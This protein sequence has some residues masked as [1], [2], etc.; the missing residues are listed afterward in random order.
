MDDDIPAPRRDGQKAGPKRSEPADQGRVARARQ[1]FGRAARPGSHE[2][3]TLSLIGKSVLAASVS[4]YIAYNLMQAQSPAFAPFSAVLI[5]Q[6]TAYQSLLQSLRYVGAV[7]VGVGLQGAVGSVTGSGM[8]TFVLVAVAALTIGRWRQL[9]SQGTQV[10]TAA[11]FA[12]STY[13]SAT[14][15]MQGLTQ[16][17]QIVLLVVIGCGVGV[18]VNVF[19]MPPM[20][21]R[22]AEHGVRALAHS[23][24]DL[25]GDIYPVLRDGELPEERAGH[26]RERAEQ[27]GPIVTQARGAVQTAWE[28]SYYNPR[29]MWQRRKRRLHSSFDGYQ[30]VV[31]AMER[32]TQQ[33]ASMTR[34]LAQWT[35]SDGSRE[36]HDFLRDYGDFLASLAH[37][38]EMMSGV[39]EDRLEAQARELCGAAEEAQEQH[40][41]VGRGAAASELPVSDPSQPYGILLA[42]ARRMMDE[43]QHTCDVLQQAVDDATA[44]EGKLSGCR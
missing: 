10:S 36:H 17:G 18:V 7:A 28:S 43:F 8:L 32:V 34:A 25:L 16:L 13:A 11:F 21:Y 20:R 22:S 23:L 14:T 40:S 1:W 31:G 5:M 37:V 38:T 35:N 9:G 26:W 24:C 39:D 12:F 6:V 15:T 4:W 19:V 33:M 29:H 27:L 3:N 41:R 2:W 30:A 44:Q 42:E